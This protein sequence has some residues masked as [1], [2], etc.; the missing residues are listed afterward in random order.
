MPGAQ[1]HASAPPTRSKRQEDEEGYD[2]SSGDESV[3]SSLSEASVSELA[4]RGV[5][6]HLG[7]RQEPSTV[8]RQWLSPLEVR[9]S[10]LKMRHLFGDGRRVADAVPLIRAE[11]CTPEETAE[12]GGIWRLET[13]FPVIEVIRWRCK[14]RDEATG[15]AKVDPATGSDLL[16]SEERWFALDNRRLYCLQEVAQ[17]LWPERCVV[18]MHEVL[19]GPHLRIRGLRK[20]RTLDVGKSIVCG[21][22]ADGVPMIRWSWRA[23][24]GISEA[25]GESD[26][27]AAQSTGKVPSPSGRSPVLAH[28]ASLKEGDY[29][30]IERSKKLSWILRRGAE[31]FNIPMEPDGWVRVNDL[32][33]LE[34]LGCETAEKFFGV[35]EDSNK[36]KRRYELKDSETGVF[37]IFIR[38][39]RPSKLVAREQAR[40]REQHPAERDHGHSLAAPSAAAPIGGLPRDKPVGY[41]SASGYSGGGYG[42]GA[43][44]QGEDRRHSAK[45]RDG[46]GGKDSKGKGGKALGSKAA[47]DGKGVPAKEE[48]PKAA[49]PAPEA[50]APVEKTG[51]RGRGGGEK[52]GS[53]RNNV[54]AGAAALAQG[55]G[56]GV[57]TGR[58][59][60]AA[61]ANAAAAAAAFP[62]PAT[63]AALAAYAAGGALPKQPGAAKGKSQKGGAGGKKGAGALPH[64]YMQA[65]QQIHHMHHVHAMYS[66]YQLQLRHQLMQLGQMQQLHHLQALAQMHQLQTAGAQQLAEMEAN[67]GADYGYNE[68]DTTAASAAAAVAAASAS[69]AYEEEAAGIEAKIMQAREAASHRSGPQPPPQNPHLQAKIDEARGVAHQRNEF[70]SKIAE[71]HEAARERRESAAAPGADP[72]WTRSPDLIV[73]IAEAR[74]NAKQRSN[75]DVEARIAE[76]LAGARQRNGAAAS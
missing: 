49:A 60:G 61:N 57:A 63:V 56:T 23:Q 25:G 47:F 65:L 2:S 37:E 48:A 11:K 4:K 74:E 16:D 72:A 28:L 10:Q 22:R 36:Q 64:S 39:S 43:I 12:H 27:E 50:K 19:S 66:Q 30:R 68:E 55:A 59:G 15:R 38:A 51:G 46:K 1:Q 58:G 71:A 67:G 42:G 5:A 69:G 41:Q 35:V 33:Q 53:S 13:P 32:L 18:D 54:G 40:Q 70:T 75:T 29:D 34:F 62:D 3:T 6:F 31:T 73:K 24:A 21:T 9:F 45:G 20:F 76:A 52:P 7:G 44:G 26:P 8:Q 14:L 17:R